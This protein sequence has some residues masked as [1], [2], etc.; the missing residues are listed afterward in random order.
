MF[1]GIQNVE[2]SMDNIVIW[3][4]GMKLHLLKVKKVLDIC[5]S[6]IV[7]LNREKCQ[8][9]VEELTFMGDQLSANGSKP[10]P[11]KVK[12]IEEFKTPKRA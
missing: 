10:D 2:T 3:G 12:L 9:V 7:T 5:K 6:N 11:A 4:S 1:E 8:I